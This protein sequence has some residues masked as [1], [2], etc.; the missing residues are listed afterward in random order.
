MNLR[1]E[2]ERKVQ[3]MAHE[4]VRS[5]ECCVMDEYIAH[6]DTFK[7]GTAAM[8]EL[9]LPCVDQLE[10]ECCCTGETDHNSEVITCE[11]CD[12]LNSLRLK[13]SAKPKGEGE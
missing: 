9:L 10:R 5:D 6:E 2:L 12:A 7:A 8:L 11:A 13:L 4:F 1:D 3:E